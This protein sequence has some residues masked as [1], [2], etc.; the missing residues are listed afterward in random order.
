MPRNSGVYTPTNGTWSNAA[1]N[2]VL[3]T[4]SD[5]QNLLTD[6]STALTQSVSKDGQTVMTNDLDMGANKLTNLAAGTTL[7][8][9]LRWQ[10]LFDQGTEVGIASATTT[11]IGAQNTA[12]LN[13]TGTTTITSFGTTYRGPRYLRF[14]G[15]V[16]LTNSS[17][18]VLPGG[19]SYTTSSGDVVIAI[20]KATGGVSDGWYVVS[21]SILN[22]AVISGNL[23]VAGAVTLSGGTANG[24]TY[25][26]GS[27]VL[28]SGSALTFDG[29][30]LGLKARTSALFY[31]ENS[32]NYARIQG[33]T[34]SGNEMI[35]FDG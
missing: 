16:T 26:N 29:F 5:W 32:D 34:G 35:F 1:A 30:A 27:K 22:N 19:A 10:Q 33:A 24:V 7:G 15:A 25:L 21:P 17:T 12:F 2:G 18:L 14:S 6:L 23:S 28:T 31:N 11:D 13:V 3:A 20:P 9:S 8:E 4:L